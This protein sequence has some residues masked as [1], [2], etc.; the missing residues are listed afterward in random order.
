MGSVLLGWLPD[1]GC[2]LWPRRCGL[3]D[4]HSVLTATPSTV[5]SVTEPISHVRILSLR[6]AQGHDREV[7]TRV[8]IATP[9]PLTPVLH[10]LPRAFAHFVSFSSILGGKE[11]PPNSTC[12]AG[13][14]VT[15]L[16][17]MFHCN[18][19]EMLQELNSSFYRLAYGKFGVTH[20]CT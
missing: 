12:Q 2:P 20:C 1:M 17:L 9:K 19:G 11:G 7:R 10:T 3:R 16:R 4:S 5:W 6:A 13:P 18:V 15:S 8:A 14:G